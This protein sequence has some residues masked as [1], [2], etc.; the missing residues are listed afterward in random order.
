MHVL[1][2]I[3]DFQ[4][5]GVER[6]ATRLAS[7]WADQGVKITLI[8]GRP[9][10]SLKLLLSDRVSLVHPFRLLQRGP[11]SRSRLAAFAARVAEHDRPDIIFLPGNF[12]AG[13]ALILR[14]ALG[15]ECPSIVCKLSNPLRRWDRGIL[16]QWAFDHAI[17][18]KTNFCDHLIFM[19]NELRQEGLQILGDIA[20]KSS[21]VDEPVLEGSCPQSAKSD[22][23]SVGDQIGLVA[24]SRL[25][26][27]KNLDLMIEAMAM[28]K[29]PST[30]LTIFGE[31]PC[32]RSLDARIRS[33]GLQRR[34]KLAG[35]SDDW[36]TD[37]RRARL[38]LL[39]SAFE[40]FPAVVIEA[41]A[42]GVPVVATDCSPAMHTILSSNELGSVVAN[43][44]P[45]AFARAID[46]RLS[47]PIPDPTT[48]AKSVERF[49]LERSAPA[50]LGI[51]SRIV[52]APEQNVPSSCRL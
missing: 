9:V 48:L 21:V 26:A 15:P 44:D 14:L 39:S 41:L 1:I 31:G 32:R 19:S 30:Q 33:L 16:R 34:V 50:Y 24:A 46:H 49:R 17:R 3:H 37:L 47:G 10:G 25:V 11:F 23:R 22:V 6:I 20:D 52:E 28:I 4:P 5:G 2:I 40:G 36:R 43:G 12:Y 29:N 7:Y 27:Q 35:Y 42:A 8:C 45:E 13:S 18:W 38:F 51:F